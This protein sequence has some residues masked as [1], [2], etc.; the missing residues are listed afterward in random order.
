MFSF[1]PFV[2]HAMCWRDLE[3]DIFNW[4]YLV[5][6]DLSICGSIFTWWSRLC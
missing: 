1:I 3:I 5:M 6:A 4:S 2:R